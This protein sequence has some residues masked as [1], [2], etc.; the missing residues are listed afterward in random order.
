MNDLASE[1]ANAVRMA[2]GLEHTDIAE[3]NRRLKRIPLSVI[4]YAYAI[5]LAHERALQ[6]E[7]QRRRVRREK[8]AHSFC[9]T[10][11]KA[12]L[13]SAATVALPAHQ[14]E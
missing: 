7:G 11:P 14:S 6:A 5:D 3:L 12:R 9:P 1:C 13:V 8:L 10:N 4:S 2:G